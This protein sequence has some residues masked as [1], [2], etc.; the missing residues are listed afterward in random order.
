MTA[1]KENAPKLVTV[2]GQ[3]TN[4][5]TIQ[6]TNG[7]VL[8]LATVY[9]LDDK[10]VKIGVSGTV[11]IMNLQDIP[12]DSFV[13]IEAEQCVKGQTT[14]EDEGVVKVHDFDG[15]FA[16]DIDRTSPTI[17]RRRFAENLEEK[18]SK[19]LSGMDAEQKSA[20]I[21]YLAKLNGL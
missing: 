4:V 1:I 19:R 14:Y 16:K 10:R 18:Y 7:K 5:K 20:E 2:F 9:G 21:G 3:L 13:E 6:R 11:G 15:L 17:F 8:K 12:M